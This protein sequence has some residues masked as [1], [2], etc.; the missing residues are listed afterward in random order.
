MR[1]PQ[2]PR[3][4]VSERFASC[5]LL[6]PHGAAVDIDRIKRWRRRRTECARKRQRAADPYGHL[7]AAIARAGA[8]SGAGRGHSV[9]HLPSASLTHSLL[10][11]LISVALPAAGS[12]AASLQIADDVLGFHAAPLS[13]SAATMARNSSRRPCRTASGGGDSKRFLSDPAV[14]GRTPTA[15]ASKAGSGTSSSTV[16]PSPLCWKTKSVGQMLPAALKPASPAFLPRL[17]NPQRI[18]A[19][20]SGSCL[21]YAR[22]A[23]NQ[24]PKTLIATGLLI[25]GRPHV[26]F[27]QNNT[28]KEGGGYKS[29]STLD[30]MMNL[31]MFVTAGSENKLETAIFERVQVTGVDSK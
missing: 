20:K 15:A 10:L 16:G 14:H 2:S 21:R 6:P 18:R 12:C 17:S 8:N 13:S 27:Y 19:G 24:H 7:A 4:G 29:N 26:D 11:R 1:V 23:S 22:P 3:A 5:F 30:G 28:T 31:E 25:G 9:K